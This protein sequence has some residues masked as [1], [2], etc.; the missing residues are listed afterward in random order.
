MPRQPR[1]AC[2]QPYAVQPC[3]QVNGKDIPLFN[4]VAKARDIVFTLGSATA[5]GTNTSASTS[6][7]ASMHV[8]SSDLGLT[9][10]PLTMSYSG[11]QYKLRLDSGTTILYGAVALSNM[12]VTT[13]QQAPV[14]RGTCTGFVV[15]RPAA[16]A[17]DITKPMAVGGDVA[18]VLSVKVQDVS[19][20]LL[21]STLWPMAIEVQLPQLLAGLTFA[22]VEVRT[23]K[24]AASCKCGTG[25]SYVYSRGALAPFLVIP[26]LRATRSD[27]AAAMPPDY[28]SWL[29]VHLLPEKTQNCFGQPIYPR[30]PYPFVHLVSSPDAYTLLSGPDASG[31]VVGLDLTFTSYGILYGS[32]R[33]DGE[34]GLDELLAALGLALP[35]GVMPLL[36]S[37]NPTFSLVANDSR[38]AN[39]TGGHEGRGAASPVFNGGVRLSGAMSMRPRGTREVQPH[40]T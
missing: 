24:N 26:L 7:S 30:C 3:T 23:P 37:S 35:A 20:D 4:G 22:N 36:D 32:V 39:L 38:G 21:A 2:A 10:A 15:G 18:V 25:G 31:L 1:P 33:L 5:S 8:S 29:V 27:T 11:G 40:P 13:T 16:I 17:L 6:L 34:M 12:T 28:A 14:L 9:L 19:L